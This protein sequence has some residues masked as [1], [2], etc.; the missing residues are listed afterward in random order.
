MNTL[1]F[2]YAV[3]IEKT[4]SINHGAKI[5]QGTPD[6][7]KTNP[8]VIEAYTGGSLERGEGSSAGSLQFR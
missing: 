4:R 2:R 1:H 6:E 8:T 7:I 3:E 5:A